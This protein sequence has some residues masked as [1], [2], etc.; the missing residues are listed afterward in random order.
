M[1]KKNLNRTLN[2]ANTISGG[3]MI[4]A[5]FSILSRVIGLFRD[6]LLSSTFGAGEILDSY[7][8]AFRLP[9]FVFQTLILGAFSSAFI[10]V[11][12]NIYSKNK[13]KAWL[14][15]NRILNLLLAIVFFLSVLFFIVAPFIIPYI[16]PGFSLS[17]KELTIKFTR[18]MMIGTIFF[19]LSNVVGSVLK[20]FQRFLVYSLAPILYNIGIVIGV[21]FLTKTPLG[22]LGLAW[23]VVLGAVLHFLIQLPIFLKTGF[24]WKPIFKFTKSIKRIISL[25]VPRCIG[26]AANQMNFI[27]VTFMASILTIGAVA[28]YNL[29]FNLV[30]IPI[31]LFGISLA[32]AI[33]PMLSRSFSLGDI[34]RFS[35]YFS[36]TV[37]VIIFI[38]VPVSVIFIALRAQ[39]VRIILG[40]GLFTWED[41]VL[42]ATMLGWFSF[43][44][45]ARSLIPIFARGFYACQN[46][47]TPV[48]I[49]VISFVLNI[50]ACII[51]GLT[52][53][54]GGLALAFAIA[55]IVNILLLYIYFNKK[56][57][58]LYHKE[59]IY[60]LVVSGIITGVMI[61]FLQVVKMTVANFVNMQTF[62]GVFLQ[63]AL[64][65][66]L[67]LAFYLAL[68]LI[69]NIKE[70]Y[71]FYNIIFKKIKKL[72]KPFKV[73]QKK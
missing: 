7:Y 56:I 51:L 34:K 57:A 49:A 53:G 59:I 30:H 73:W 28:V 62:L 27:V 15:T 63:G 10:P 50:V 60:T 39:I 38:T 65:G 45:I 70:A 47:K 72:I 33:F 64:A 24:K 48:I 31:S 11:F 2:Q 32:V 29:A 6:R 13:E 5:L 22:I 71:I 16:V 61:M 52:M 18:I 23:G 58:K 19:T 4:I 54:V 25:M 26:L 67:S 55:S 43:S 35:H 44:I 40:A 3:A 37:R 8:A 46:T 41:T 69:F 21:L 68:G 9:D 66:S 36:K 42:T 20:S 17:A 12:L 1:F 14:L